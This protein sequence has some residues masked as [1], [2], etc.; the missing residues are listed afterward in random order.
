M[1]ALCSCLGGDSPKESKEP[2]NQ[3][4]GAVVNPSEASSRAGLAAIQRAEL[5]ANTPAGKAARKVAKAKTSLAPNRGGEPALKRIY[6]MQCS[7]LYRDRLANGMMMMNW[8]QASCLQP[9]GSCCSVPVPNV[10]CCLLLFRQHVG[11][12]TKAAAVVT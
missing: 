8:S 9:P 7:E 10:L 5:F 1:G 11:S 6:W 2:N 3:A 4:P 12:E